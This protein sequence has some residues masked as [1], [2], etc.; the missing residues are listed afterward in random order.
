[1]FRATRRDAVVWSVWSARRVAAARN[2]ISGRLLDEARNQF[3]KPHLS[4]RPPSVI[5]GKDV[6]TN[7]RYAIYVIFI[8]N[9][10]DQN[11]VI[12]TIRNRYDIGTRREPVRALNREQCGHEALM[13][14]NDSEPS[15]SYSR[16]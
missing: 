3:Q 16:D 1:M 12:G 13:S 15:T 11:D 14:A 5:A 9:L 7:S 10:I 6:A 4:R 8:N 2:T